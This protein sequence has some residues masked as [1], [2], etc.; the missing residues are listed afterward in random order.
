MASFEKLP[1]TSAFIDRPTYWHEVALETV[2][3]SREAAEDGALVLT[4]ELIDVVRRNANAALN[5]LNRVVSAK[6][7]AEIF[8]LQVTHLWTQ[9]GAVF[10]QAE[11]L[12]ALAMGVL[13][14]IAQAC[15]IG[16]A[17]EPAREPSSERQTTVLPRA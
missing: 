3:R 4:C 8:E 10:R 6:S 12:R 17:S 1:S 15:A 5:F 7:P 16:S 9:F 11:E 2:Q 14:D 13:T